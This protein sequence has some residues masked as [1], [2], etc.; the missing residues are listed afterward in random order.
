VDDMNILI[1]DDHALLRRGLRQI[2]AEGMTDASFE[3]ATNGDELMAKLDARPTDIVL[4][5]ISM[6]GKNGLELLQELR[7]KHPRCSV[8][9]LSVHSEKQYAVRALKAGAAGYLTKDVA[10]EALVDAVNKVC[11]GGRYVTAS[12]AELLATEIASADDRPPHEL[13]SNREDAIFRRLAGGQSVGQIAKTMEL[14]VKTVSTYRARVLAK[15]KMKTNAELMRY[16]VDR[17]LVD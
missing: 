2:L 17:K 16:A 7:E 5:D 14:S 8:L 3:E 11:A 1:A 10:P 13:L 9:V 6:P 15:M 12:L 4:L